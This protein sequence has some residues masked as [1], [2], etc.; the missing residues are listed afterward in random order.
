MNGPS[1]PNGCAP[2]AE[3]LPELALGILS[4]AERADVLAH[5][6]R[7]ASCRAELESWAATADL[8]PGLLGEAEPPAGF[9]G[10]TLDRL[11]TEQALE[12]RWPIWR[13]VLTVAA[14]VA[15]AMIVTLA[16]VRI[17]DAGSDSGSGRVAETEMVNAPMVGR[18]GHRAG[19]AFM[20][21]GEERYLFVDVDYGVGSGRYDIEAVDHADN[22]TKVGAVDVKEGHGAWAGELPKGA[23]DPEMVRMVDADG[24]VWC[25]AKFGPVAT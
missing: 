19:D 22:T 13:R 1:V 7:C 8:L 21:G 2:T 15:M 17:I 18:S 9:E 4:G 12:P 14:I 10:R 24:K 3:R 25:W 23:A 20:T 6:D 5:L 11:R 16:A